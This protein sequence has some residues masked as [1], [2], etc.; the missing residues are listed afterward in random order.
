MVLCN[1]LSFPAWSFALFLYLS[2]LY[3]PGKPIYSCHALWFPLF[4]S[5]FIPS[6]FPKMCYP[7]LILFLT[8]IKWNLYAFLFNPCLDFVP[9]LRIPIARTVLPNCVYI[10]IS[11]YL[12][13]Y[14]YINISAVRYLSIFHIFL[15]DVRPLEAMIICF[16]Y[17]H[18]ITHSPITT[19]YLT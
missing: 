16:L 19:F 13:M 11:I 1:R 15:Q 9:L 12:H 6:H 3:R 5:L 7:I 10:C 2:L 8:R 4:G 18:Y 17:T 14:D